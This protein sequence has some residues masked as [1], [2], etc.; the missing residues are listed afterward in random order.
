VDFLLAGRDAAVDQ[1]QA[2]ARGR[3]SEGEL[4]S[5]GGRDRLAW[6]A[7]YQRCPE[8]SEE[9]DRT[10]RPVHDSLEQAFRGFDHDCYPIW[11]DWPG[12]TA[13]HPRRAPVIERMR[14]AGILDLPGARDGW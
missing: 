13:A 11:R 8:T 4:A 5:F 6:T 14:H 2:G 10:P 9:R 1:P 7:V 12:D 3:G